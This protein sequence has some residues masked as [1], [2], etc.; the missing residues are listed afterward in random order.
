VHVVDTESASS[1]TSGQR[2]RK[3]KVLTLCQKTV[4]A[5]L[6]P[7]PNVVRGCT[8]DRTLS[9]WSLQQNN[10]LCAKAGWDRAVLTADTGICTWA[11]ILCRYTSGMIPAS[12]C[13]PAPSLEG[14]Q[15]SHRPTQPSSMAYMLYPNTLHSPTCTRCNLVGPSWTICAPSLHPRRALPLCVQTAAAHGLGKQM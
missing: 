10:T 14:H 15:A 11:A 3:V 8:S 2:K 1:H 6:G 4:A 13:L 5:Y 9:T 12:Y 7:L